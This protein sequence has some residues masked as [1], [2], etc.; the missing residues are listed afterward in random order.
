[1]KTK[2]ND[3]IILAADK[4]RGQVDKGGSPYI[5]HPLRVMQKAKRDEER[6]VAVLH[7]VVED[8]DV[9]LDELRVMGFDER[10][11]TAIDHLTRR[12]GETYNDFILRVKQNELATRVKL[13]DIED[14]S[15]LSRLQEVTEQDENRLRRYQKA[16]ELLADR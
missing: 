14:N 5:L 12:G 16:V 9:T 4:H 11:V 15:D 7:D 6:I 1:M 8:T 2:L 10:I 3:A 13:L